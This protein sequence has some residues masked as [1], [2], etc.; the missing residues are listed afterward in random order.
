MSARIAIY[1]NSSLQ[2]GGCV[3]SYIP[4]FRMY[5]FTGNGLKTHFKKAYCF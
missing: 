5:N 3:L 2:G 4:D 1:M